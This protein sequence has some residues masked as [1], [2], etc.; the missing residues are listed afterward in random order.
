MATFVDD[1]EVSADDIGEVSDPDTCYPKGLDVYDLSHG[2]TVS[3][4]GCRG[5][6]V[7][8]LFHFAAEN[9]M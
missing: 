1:L 7:P 5:R 3:L 2:E 4:N 8:R 6:V 9:R